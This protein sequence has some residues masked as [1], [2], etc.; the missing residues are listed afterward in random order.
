MML[1]FVCFSL[2]SYNE[3]LRTLLILAAS[4]IKV[5][6]FLLISFIC[7]IV[8]SYCILLRVGTDRIPV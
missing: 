5:K 3:A 4:N 7:I 8:I 1:L 6:V 2:S